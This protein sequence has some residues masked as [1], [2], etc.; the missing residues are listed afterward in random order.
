MNDNDVTTRDVTESCDVEPIYDD[1]WDMIRPSFMTGLETEYE[2][3][4]DGLGGSKGNWFKYMQP[5]AN[6]AN[7]NFP[8]QQTKHVATHAVA[9]PQKNEKKNFTVSRRSVVTSRDANAG[10]SSLQHR[11]G[12]L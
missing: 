9:T 1:P 3:S 12:I 10:I 6:K 5:T 2:V 4:T 7:H 11:Q 8:L